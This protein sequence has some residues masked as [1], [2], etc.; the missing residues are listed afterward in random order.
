MPPQT[1]NNNAI[2]AKLKKQGLGK[3]VKKHK[4]DAI[5]LPKSGG[6]VPPGIEAG[7]AQLI[8]CR[9]S[10]RKEGEHKG[11]PF[12][13]LQAIVVDVQ[14]ENPVLKKAIKKRIFN[15]EDLFDTPK[16]SKTKTF[17]QHLSKALNKLRLLGEDTEQIDTDDEDS[18]LAA[19]VEILARL[20]E[21]KPC[22]EFKTWI[23]KPSKAFPN[24]K[25]NV[26]WGMRVDDY[27]PPDES[28]SGVVDESADTSSTESES[29]ADESTDTTSDESGESSESSDEVDWDALAVE[30]T[31]DDKAAKEAI[32][33]KAEELGLKD[34]VAAAE[35]WAD[36]VEM[37]KAAMEAGG[38]GS[39]TTADEA[40]WVPEVGKVYKTKPAGEKNKIDIKV[41]KVNTKNKT[42][43]AKG[44]ANK[45]D[46]KGLKW[47][48]ED[49]SSKINGMNI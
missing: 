27:T 8:V 35:S 34:E 17:D 40:P 15:G 41:V 5:E 42:L 38:G 43:D 37:I 48:N 33:A 32:E 7:I 25:V 45:K 20:E 4:G 1:N 11:K 49:G 22:F 13:D 12:L 47:S 30:A 16:S 24:P 46:Y 18:T 29:A 21:E 19:M 28:E 36:A 2:L 10:E 9:F 23:G 14:D 39:D 31:N 26:D 44:V 6:T 3:G